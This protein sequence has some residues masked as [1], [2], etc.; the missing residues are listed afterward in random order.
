VDLGLLVSLD[1]EAAGARA[2][3]EDAWLVELVADLSSVWL[4]Y[5]GESPVGFLAVQWIAGEGHVQTVGVVPAFRRRGVART[6]LER[7]AVA[8]PGS[9]PIPWHLEVRSD[10]QAA[11]A[12]YRGLGFEEVGCRRGYYT[13]G[14]DAILMSRSV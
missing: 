2:W 9:G 7:A 6:L 10:N 1:R 8:P 4:A 5:F 11:R 12:L 13:G 14:F 3:S